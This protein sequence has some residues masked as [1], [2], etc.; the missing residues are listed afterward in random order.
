MGII[1]AIIIIGL[2]VGIFLYT[3]KQKAKKAAIKS[4]KPVR[5]GPST[6]TG[7]TTTSSPSKSDYYSGKR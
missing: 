6:G 2:G 7:A 4:T 3:K 1:F 5:R